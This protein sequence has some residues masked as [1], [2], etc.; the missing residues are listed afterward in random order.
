LC[1]GYGWVASKL[2]PRA[3]Y[4]PVTLEDYLTD[5]QARI[6]AL[7]VEMAKLKTLPVINYSGLMREGE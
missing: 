3:L 6:A 2:I 4:G 1:N 7:E 5:M